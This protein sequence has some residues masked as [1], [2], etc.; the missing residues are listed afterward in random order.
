[1]RPDWAKSFA[2]HSSAKR[3]QE[4]PFSPASQ[5]DG[6]SFAFFHVTQWWRNSVIR[7]KLAAPIS[8]SSPAFA[9]LSTCVCCSLK[10]TTPSVM[11]K[12]KRRFDLGRVFLDIDFE[13][14]TSRKSPLVSLGEYRIWSGPIFDSATSSLAIVRIAPRELPPRR[15]LSSAQLSNGLLSLPLSSLSKG[16]P[17]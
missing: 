2:P 16:L 6:E 3:Q 1:M 15:T 11:Q 7:Q 13:F 4:L 9:V 10:Q 8:P 12:P 17:L 5:R 14:L